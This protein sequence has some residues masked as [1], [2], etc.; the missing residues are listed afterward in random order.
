MVWGGV[1]TRIPKGPGAGGGGACVVVFITITG[2]ALGLRAAEKLRGQGLQSCGEL[3]WA[4]TQ[5][6][7]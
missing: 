4:W 1:S 3:C 2:F 6:N 7:G 5:V